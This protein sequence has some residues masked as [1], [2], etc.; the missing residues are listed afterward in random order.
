MFGN[1]DYIG[2]LETEN[3]ELK[4]EIHR[5]NDELSE[6]LTECEQLKAEGDWSNAK[7]KS[8]E[9]AS[10]EISKL[11]AELKAQKAETRLWKK[12]TTEAAD[13]VERFEQL[14][15]ENKRLNNLIFKE[16]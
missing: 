4:E 10:A 13:A 7:W 9:I 5:Y 15:A 8:I 11:E 6:A 1:E 12:R 16:K 2:R 14:K 3:K